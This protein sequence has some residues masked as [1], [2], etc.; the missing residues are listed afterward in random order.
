METTIRCS[1]LYLWPFV[2]ANTVMMTICTG[3]SPMQGILLG[4]SLSLMS[5]FGFLI[6]DLI[7]RKVD[8]LNGAKRME[9]ANKITIS[10]SFVSAISFLS[11]SLIMSSLISLKSL[12]WMSVIG[13]GL[14]AYSVFCRKVLLLATFTSATLSA[15]PLWLPLLLWRND[16]NTFFINFSGLFFLLL[17]AR[18][19]LLDSKDVKGD[20]QGGR[21]TIGTVFGEKISLITSIVLIAASC[22][23]LVWLT[24]VK[25]HGSWSMTPLLLIAFSVGYFNLVPACAALLGKEIVYYVTRSRNSMILVSLYLLIA[26]T[27][28]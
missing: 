22:L 26:G 4:T 12:I 1:R 19:I 24:A 9:A 13:L 8:N 3:K 11:L 16:E 28:G 2:L 18:E 23:T 15:S 14:I 27:T 21:H 10:I 7:D 25:W 6:N 5:S 17:I 20:Q